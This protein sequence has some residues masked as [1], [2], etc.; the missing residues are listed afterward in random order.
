MDGVRDGLNKPVIAVVAWALLIALNFAVVLVRV[1]W[2]QFPTGGY[3]G[4]LLLSFF[5]GATILM[6]GPAVGLAIVAST[7]LN[8]YGVGLAIGIGTALGEMVGYEGGRL[9]S[10]ALLAFPQWIPRFLADW[11]KLG[12]EL[13]QGGNPLIVFGSLFLLAAAPNPFFDVVGMGSGAARISR[14]LFLVAVAC[15]R[16]LRYTGLALVAVHISQPT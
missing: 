2:E 12:A 9:G 16:V 14:L 13:I 3:A 4:I 7:V 8:P 1:P 11:L 10:D 15:G 5:S 6:P